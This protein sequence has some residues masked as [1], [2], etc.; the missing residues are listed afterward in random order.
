MALRSPSGTPAI[1]DSLVGGMVFLRFFTP[2]I[3]DAGLVR[4]ASAR[5][6]AVHELRMARR[7]TQ[8]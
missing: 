1:A 4:P 2:A 6:A 7:W 5:S 8:S 3:I